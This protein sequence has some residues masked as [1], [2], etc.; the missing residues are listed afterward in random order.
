MTH[1]RAVELLAEAGSELVLRVQPTGQVPRQRMAGEAFAWED[2]QGKRLPGLHAA[3]T[4]T[5]DAA[6][7]T[8]L[9]AVRGFIHT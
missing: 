2:A 4:A 8:P 1:A 6:D 3:E 7:D 5:A 9:L